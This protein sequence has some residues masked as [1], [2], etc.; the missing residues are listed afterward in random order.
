MVNVRRGTDNGGLQ[1]LYRISRSAWS[2]I[3]VAFDDELDRHLHAHLRAVYPLQKSRKALSDQRDSQF[4]QDLAAFNEITV[5]A[6]RASPC[7]IQYCYCCSNALSKSQ[8]RIA[9]FLCAD[10]SR[11]E[12]MMDEFKW[13]W[14]S[15]TSLVNVY[16]N[17]VRPARIPLR[18]VSST[19]C[20]PT[21]EE[22]R[23]RIA[24]ILLL[25]QEVRDPRRRPMEP[26]TLSANPT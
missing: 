18:F 12:R 21:Q 25:E 4:P 5:P 2:D 17:S 20:H 15:V 16:K 22:F 6:I 13:P 9:R 23:A 19:R 3:T 26:S 14:R 1:R 10:D 7:V 11:K 8:L 24:A